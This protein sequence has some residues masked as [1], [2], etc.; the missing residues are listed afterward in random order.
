MSTEFLPRRTSDESNPYAPPA[1]AIDV[2]PVDLIPAGDL[3]SAEAVRQAHLRHETSVKSIGRLHYLGAFIGLL[4]ACGII[5]TALT[6]GFPGGAMRRGVMV[7]TGVFYLA[8]GGL[9]LA[10]GIGLTRLQPW[11]RWTDVV[12][13][14]LGLIFYGLGGLM[15]VFVRGQASALVGL[16]VGSLILGYILYLLLSAK[17]ST[18]FS[19]EYKTIIAQTP[20][21]KYRMSPVLKIFLV[22]LIVVF[23]I[24]IV[25]A[26]VPRPR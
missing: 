10:I 22:L 4:A 3:T 25:G 20:H 13:T 26:L 17:S 11:A 2:E 23:V 19:A 16:F 1:T 6:F 7:G 5:I 9:Q 12:L 15:N 14:A 8:T 21:I 24:G 18:I